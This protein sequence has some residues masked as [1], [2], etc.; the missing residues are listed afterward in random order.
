MARN[1]VYKRGR[2]NYRVTGHRQLS[3]NSGYLKTGRS[4][5]PSHAP[6]WWSYTSAFNGD[7][8]HNQ[9]F[10]TVGDIVKTKLEGKSGNRMSSYKQGWKNSNLINQIKVIQNA[11]E[12]EEQAFLRKYQINIAPNEWGRLIEFFTVAFSSE[13]SFNR[14]LQL[15]KQV[16]DGE[17]PI[18]H[19]FTAFLSGYVQK[20]ARDIID[21]HKNELV[22][23]TLEEVLP[24]I[25]DQIIE[26]ALN[27]M[28]KMTDLKLSNGYIETHSQKQKKLQGE[29]IQAYQYLIKQIKIFMNSP[30]KKLVIADLGLTEQFLKDTVAVKLQN[31]GKRGGKLDKL[32]VLKSSIKNGNVRG[33]V[34]EHFSK[35]FL[36]QATEQWNMKIGNDTFWTTI[37]VGKRGAKTDVLGH[38]LQASAT[39]YIPDISLLYSTAGSNDSKRVNAIDN[40]EQFFQTLK[41]AEG[42]I[43]FVSDK[44]YQIT[45]GFEGYSIQDGVKLKNLTA[46]LQKVGYQ[47]GDLEQLFEYLSNCGTNM[48][49]SPAAASNVLTEVATYV[50]HFLFDDLTITG[51]IGGVNRV[52]LLDLSGFYMPLSVYMGALLQAAETA[53]ERSAADMDGFVH[54]TFHGKGKP[55]QEKGWSGK[56][57]FDKFRETRLEESELEFK[58]MQDITDFI[59]KFFTIKM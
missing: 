1:L 55:P 3:K 59:L 23:K 28:F 57:D 42:E 6:I 31:Q 30:F 46:L 26:L 29:E 22:N 44:N 20:A 35:I 8:E 21:K 53:Q 39:G 51:G 45:Q 2:G 17:S 5:F 14:N 34:R 49:L 41:E 52:H 25:N 32:P 33:S 56:G 48:L 7:G 24:N 37:E 4:F 15:L 16:Q 50:G 38:K 12:K 40:A 43:V 11:A 36:E 10:T 27:R 13:E 18:Y 47:G 54:I 58:I 19:D 9:G